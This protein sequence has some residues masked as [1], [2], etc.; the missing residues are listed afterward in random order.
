MFKIKKIPLYY[1]IA[2]IYTLILFLDRID[3]TIINV[4]IPTLSQLFNINLALTDWL[5]TSFLIG[6]SI[7]IAVSS[8]LGEK[9]GYKKIFINA[10]FGFGIL[11]LACA[12]SSNFYQFIIFRFL[13]GIFGGIIIPTGSAILYMSCEKKDYAKVTAFAF[14]PTLIAPAIAPYL[15]G[16]ILKYFSYRVIFYINIPICILVALLGMLVIKD[17]FKFQ[18]EKFDFRGFFMSSLLY[19]G[20]FVDLSFI[21][22]NNLLHAFIITPFV[23]LLA[24]VFFYTEKKTINPLINFNYFKNELF[25]KANLI[26]MFF[27]MS[28]FGSFFIIGLFLQVGLGFSPAQAGLVIAMQ[29]LGAMIVTIPS[30]EL[31]YTKGVVFPLSV[32]LIGISLVTPCILFISSATDI[33]LACIIMFIR[34]LCSGW[35]GTPL[36]T[37]SMLDQNIDKKDLGRIGG[38]FNITRQL[39]ISLG[40]C[41]SA[42]FIGITN[43]FYHFDYLHHT[44]GY[45]NALK[46]FSLGIFTISLFCWIATYLTFKIDN[47]LVLSLCEK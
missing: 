13:Q 39:S 2:I 4:A 16:I 38:M 19:I 11:S 25:L 30:K 37:M 35:I 1:K 14:L 40:I 24:I 21:S 41:I 17:Q 15:G 29:A 47:H 34:G 42:V 43:Y 22:Q 10:V 23:I 3:I 28:H 27:Q 31:F 20:F 46:L 44:L 45:S 33:F 26:Q 18:S 9:Y 32:G 12:F 7:S 5:S 36:H 6:V 8:W